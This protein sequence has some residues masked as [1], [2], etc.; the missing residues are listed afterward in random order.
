MWF[1]FVKDSINADTI[2]HCLKIIYYMVGNY[3]QLI[4]SIKG[5][6]GSWL[7]IHLHYTIIPFK[8]Y[9]TVFFV[10]DHKFH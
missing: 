5:Q 4:L 1:E 10:S 9:L 2:P 6:S 8:C 3:F 7:T